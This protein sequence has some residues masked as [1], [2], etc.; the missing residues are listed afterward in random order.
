MSQ[1]NNLQKRIAHKWQIPVFV[2]SMAL[3]GFALI[4]VRP[5]ITDIPLDESLDLMDEQVEAGAFDLAFKLGQELL[6]VTE[7][8]TDRDFARVKL[9]LARARHDQAVKER[10]RTPDTGRAI[11][12][13]Y[14][15]AV[16][17]ELKLSAEDH[18]RW[19]RA[20]G[21]LGDHA[22]SLAHLEK[23]LQG[24][25]RRIS[26][27]RWRAYQLRDALGRPAEE[28]LAFLD[29]FLAGL[30]PEQLELRLWGIEQKIHLLSETGQSDLA[31]TLLVREREVFENTDL[32]EGL[33]YLGALLLYK[34]G[35]FDEAEAML[36]SIRNRIEV[37]DDV[38]A[39]TGWLLGHV[40]M[41]DNGPKRPYESISFFRDVMRVYADSPYGAACQLG[42]GEALAMVD[43]HDAALDAFNVAISQMPLVKDRRLVSPDVVRVSLGLRAQEQKDSGRLRAA[44]AYASLAF[45]LVDQKDTNRT[46]ATL[47]Q[48]NQ[49]QELLADAIKERARQATNEVE[50][51]AQLVEATEL[52]RNA[53]RGAVEVAR[54]AVLDERLEAEASWRAAELFA[55]AGD[56]Q[57]AA[58]HYQEFTVERPGHSLVPRA[59]L[60]IGQ[61][62][63]ADG[64]LEGAIEGYRV[65]YSSH[66]R[67]I[68]GLRALIPLAQCYMALG[69]EQDQMVEATLDIV[70]EQ[71]A[72]FTPDAPEFADALFLYG[73]VL[74][75]RGAFEEAI[76]KVEE[77]I[78][79]Y[80]SD[81]RIWSAKSLLADCYR[82]S[83]LALKQEVLKATS[84]A[85]IEH[86]HKEAMKRFDRARALYHEVTEEFSLRNP[87]LLAPLEAVN[88]RHGYV[89]EADCLFEM[90]QYGEARKLYEEVASRHKDTTTALAAYV[91]IVNCHVFLGQPEEARS[92]LARARMLVDTMPET[93]F[94]RSVSPEKRQD[95]SRY[96]TWLE[97]AELF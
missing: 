66:K 91:Q 10:R 57:L 86:M 33:N 97:D 83:A 59:L 7:G 44:L 39:R 67:T 19:G 16:E 48:L 55:K 76:G 96:F 27:L 35:S 23:A 38:Y 41:R 69:T 85:E 15:E 6:G 74:S 47:Q 71:S 36:R 52:Y 62:K 8:F 37:I 42:L 2:I 4:R 14:E 77:A 61:L 11:I 93:A 26:I 46:I 30:T 78:D 28:L 73:E 94:A 43:R 13:D 49:I 54:M 5:K 80:P 75:R 89:Y 1:W 72:V 95:W 60:R 17:Y 88:L 20:L 21:W 82:Q 22:R 25:P 50:M 53:A 68:D 29:E 34:Q 84:A 92:A 3:L 56:R 64:D 63:Q 12:G 87:Q 45:E 31:A 18:A 65:C 9:R 79:R 51:I 70:L 32:E 90:A 58:E 40:V 81:E 24:K